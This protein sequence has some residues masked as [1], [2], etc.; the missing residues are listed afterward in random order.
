MVYPCSGD[1]QGAGGDWTLWPF[2]I[3]AVFRPS[4]DSYWHS[5]MVASIL[6]LSPLLTRI[7]FTQPEVVHCHSFLGFDSLQYLDATNSVTAPTA[8]SDAAE[9]LGFWN[10]LKNKSELYSYKT[11][12]SLLSVFCQEWE[13]LCL[14]LQW[15]ECSWDSR[16]PPHPSFTR[17]FLIRSGSLGDSSFWHSWNLMIPHKLRIEVLKN[18]G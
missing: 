8:V 4:R 12:I 14:D 15:T 3:T 10:T 17:F 16:G 9:K 6:F 11:G 13:P 7:L 2:K 5:L 1:G 18:R